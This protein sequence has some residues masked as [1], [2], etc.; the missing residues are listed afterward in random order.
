VLVTK[1]KY[2]FIAIAIVLFGFE[3]TERTLYGLRILNDQQSTFDTIYDAQ[4]ATVCLGISGGMCIYASLIFHKLKR[5]SLQFGTDLL[6]LQKLTRWTI[7]LSAT[8][9]VA[10]IAIL[11]IVSLD[12]LETV[13]G[14]MASYTIDFGLEIVLCLE[15]LHLMQPAKPRK[16][17]QP[18]NLE[19][20]IP[21]M[22]GKTLTSESQQTLKSK[23]I[24]LQ[25]TR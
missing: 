15:M 2:V 3:F 6:G 24:E 7:I 19:Q 1:V 16:S 18:F 10:V 20:A 8:L 11:I 13:V 22:S 23:E 9:F 12:A 25:E 4:L 17:T 14:G 21:H 5:N